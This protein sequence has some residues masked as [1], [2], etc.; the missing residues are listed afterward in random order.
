MNQLCSCLP[1]KPSCN[2]NGTQRQN[3]LQ[4]QMKEAEKQEDLFPAAVTTNF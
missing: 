3:Q 4:G 2:R 1:A